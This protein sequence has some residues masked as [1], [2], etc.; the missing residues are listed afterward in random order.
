MGLKFPEKSKAP[1][2]VAP[3]GGYHAQTALDPCCI[4]GGI[5]SDP[6]VARSGGSDSSLGGAEWAVGHIAT[7]TA[8]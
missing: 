6:I 1:A 4:P 3:E 7:P 2:Y 5:T 8:H